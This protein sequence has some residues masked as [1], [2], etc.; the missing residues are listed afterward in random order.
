MIINIFYIKATHNFEQ[1]NVI[2][3]NYAYYK[4]VELTLR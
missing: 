2:T 3:P 4:I 1:I